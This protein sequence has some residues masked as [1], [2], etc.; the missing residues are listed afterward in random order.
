MNN[1]PMLP[2]TDNTLIFETILN[3]ITTVK[4]LLSD[5]WVGGGGGV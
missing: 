2:V 1:I 5:G 3:M 4:V